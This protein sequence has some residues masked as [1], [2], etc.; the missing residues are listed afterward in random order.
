MKLLLVL[1]IFLYVASADAAHRFPLLYRTDTMQGS[2][3]ETA[4]PPLD[5]AWKFT[6]LGLAGLG[7]L[8]RKRI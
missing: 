6:L 7:F 1:A 5:H 3:T 4:K 8:I 2:V